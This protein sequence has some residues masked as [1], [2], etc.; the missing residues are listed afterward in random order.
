MLGEQGGVTGI[1]DDLARRGID[2]VGAWILGRNMFGPVRGPWLDE[3][4]K[5]WWG[6][7]PPYHVPVYVL[8]HYR[9]DPIQM[10]GGTTFHFVTE[11]IDEALARAKEAA[12]RKDV[13]LGGGVD[14][15]RQYLRAGLVN[16]LHLAISPV[17]LGAGEHL[18]VDQDLLELGYRV[19]EH[20]TSAAA[21]HV[22]LGRIGAR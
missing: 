10:E 19:T 9:R 1:D 16:E 20:V 2:N 3:A 15:I 21:M 8:T 18:L 14:T 22:V 17:L 7:N 4:W 13:R 6:D 12:G 5:G 11:G